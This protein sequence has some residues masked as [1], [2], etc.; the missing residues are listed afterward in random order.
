MGEIKEGWYYC[1]KGHK[2]S[3]KIEYDSIVKNTP[4]YCKHCRKAYYPEIRGGKICDNNSDYVCIDGYIF[5]SELVSV[6]DF[7]YCDIPRITFMP[8]EKISE[9]TLL[10]RKR[11]MNVI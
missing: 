11:I 4:V 7:S 9:M 1:P 8:K 10:V 6:E 2:T 3:Q 5:D